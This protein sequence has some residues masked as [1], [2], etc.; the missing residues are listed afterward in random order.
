MLN[1]KDFS[2]LKKKMKPNDEQAKLKAYRQN[3]LIFGSRSSPFQ[4]QW[5]LK[6]HAKEHNNFYLENFT[7]LDDIFVGD[8]DAKKVAKELMNL[9]QVLKEGDFP[10]Q[11][12]V[13]NNMQVLKD[14]DES[15]KGP[16][17][18]HKIYGQLWNLKNDQITLNFEKQKVISEEKLFQKS[19]E[20]KL[21]WDEKLPNPLQENFQKW[22]TKESSP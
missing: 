21:D 20:L 15:Q 4:A 10:A 13:S 7:Y 17:D 1:I 5:V 19:C 22:A 2:G 11:K 3:R 14:L 9:I 12:I 16:K 8:N 6:K 18:I